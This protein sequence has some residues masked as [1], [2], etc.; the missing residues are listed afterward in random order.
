MIKARFQANAPDYRPVVS[1]THPFW[2]SGTAGDDSYSI[3][4]A[5]AEDEVDILR[6]WPEAAQIDIFEEDVKEFEYSDRFPKPD[7]YKV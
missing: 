1:A 6:L 5:Y 2:C 4:I 3:I 7:W